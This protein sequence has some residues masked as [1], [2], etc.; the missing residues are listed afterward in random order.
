MVLKWTFRVTM[1]HKTFMYTK[2]WWWW[3]GMRL[4]RCLLC[5]LSSLSSVFFG[6]KKF[7]I[8][9]LLMV[10]KIVHGDLCRK[11]SMEVYVT[12]DGLEMSQMVLKWLT[13]V[14]WFSFG[15]WLWP[16]AVV[17]RGPK[18]T[19]QLGG[20]KGRVKVLG[21]RHG[22]WWRLVQTGVSSCPW[23]RSPLSWAQLMTLWMEV[24]LVVK[25][26]VT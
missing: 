10:L 8:L 1:V 21:Q 19:F 11:L 26:M 20:L 14:W 16:V 12:H 25:M 6:V 17:C 24:M 22:V 23:V 13:Y 4:S 9:S 2:R 5:H 18:V 3:W 15:P 7:M